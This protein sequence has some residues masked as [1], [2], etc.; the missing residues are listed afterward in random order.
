MVPPTTASHP[1]SKQ[2]QSDIETL[3]VYVD[4]TLDS[5]PTGPT[6]DDSLKVH[7]MC[8]RIHGESVGE[9]IA[10][11]F[12]HRYALYELTHP[13]LAISHVPAVLQLLMGVEEMRARLMEEVDRV[14]AECARTSSNL[15]PQ[16]SS[17][18]AQT[19]RQLV[20]AD[21]QGR[22]EFVRLVVE[23]YTLGVARVHLAHVNP[24]PDRDPPRTCSAS[25]G[26]SCTC[27]ASPEGLDQ[28]FPSLTSS[29]ISEPEH[30]RIKNVHK[31]IVK[32]R[33]ES[34]NRDGDSE[35]DF[36][37]GIDPEAIGHRIDAYVD[38]VHRMMSVLKG[39]GLVD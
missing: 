28:V 23:V 22:A 27:F 17:S 6:K 26:E 37:P 12:M 30:S 24:W 8:E 3:N 31:Q 10:P 36:P 34:F 20:S 33:S 5:S 2:T 39:M 1:I 7:A 25:P 32:W 29:L 35:S 13:A 18:S 16:A 4:A 21:K 9:P 19:L 11:F 15:R 38:G 14:L